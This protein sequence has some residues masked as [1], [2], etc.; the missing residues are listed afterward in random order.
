MSLTYI[1][2]EFLTPSFHILWFCHILCRRIINVSFC[3]NCHLVLS[4]L[5][6]QYLSYSVYN[7]IVY[8]FHEL[9]TILFRSYT[10]V[11]AVHTVL[12]KFIFVVFIF[13][14]LSTC[15]ILL[16]RAS[17]SIHVD[18][19]NDL[20]TVGTVVDNT[21]KFFSHVTTFSWSPLCW[22]YLLSTL[23]YL[24]LYPQTNVSSMISIPTFRWMIPWHCFGIHVCNIR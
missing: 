20:I 15:T 12:Q 7:C 4:T 10:V 5:L 24:V 6:L 9:C 23:G 11:Y 8:G 17:E 13:C 21:F 16:S 2:R 22:S 3:L 18:F 14:T 19:S 1:L